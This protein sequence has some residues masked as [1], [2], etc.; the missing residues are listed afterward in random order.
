M[1]GASHIVRLRFRCVG[2]TSGIGVLDKAVLVLAHAAISPVTLGDLVTR[3]GLPKATA[4]RIAM[5][6][7]GHRLLI[8]TGSGAW[9]PGP[10]L[11]EL[12]SGVSPRLTSRAAPVLDRLC[13]N[14]GE[15]AQL[16]QRQGDVRVCTAMSERSSGLR[17]TVPLSARLPLTAG[18]A[19]HV[20]L[21]WET[22]DSADRD[23][24]LERA[25]FTART[26]ADVRRR[27]YAHSR[28][29]RE[30]GVA[31]VS[32]P[33]RDAYGEV[34][35]AVSISGPIARL[36]GRPKPEVVQAVLA[37]ADELGG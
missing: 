7:E 21:A 16:F 1:T 14:T 37:A 31:S 17:D 13:Q 34:V 24:I 9:A 18:S 3:L 29:E 12:S 10:R 5:A 20:L 2:H 28:A 26:L 8:R 27:G 19:A 25:S 30:P 36:G 6:L 4:H 22:I 23:A 33:V 11:A 32:A 35:A 15:S